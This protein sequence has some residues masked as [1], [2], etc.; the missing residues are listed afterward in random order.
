VQDAFWTVV[1]KIDTFR[2]ESALG[3]GSTASWRTP[4][5]RTRGRRAAAESSRWTS[6]CVFAR[7]LTSRPGSFW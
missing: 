4:P 5:T 3:P 6:C 2:G 1:R 7:A